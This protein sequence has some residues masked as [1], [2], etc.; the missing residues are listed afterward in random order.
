[1]YNGS[2]LI[3]EYYK[4]VTNQYNHDITDGEIYRIYQGMHFWIARI[5]WESTSTFRLQEKNRFL[6]ISYIT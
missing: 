1:M 4:S 6:Y 2:K 5:F 3:A